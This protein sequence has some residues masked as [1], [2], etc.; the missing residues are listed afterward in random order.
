MQEREKAMCIV[1]KKRLV[2]NYIMKLFNVII[3]NLWS[4]KIV[5][6]LWSNKINLF[7]ILER[8]RSTESVSPSLFLNASLIPYF[9]ARGLANIIAISRPKCDWRRIIS[10][11]NEFV[12]VKN[13]FVYQ[14]SRTCVSNLCI[15]FNDMCIKNILCI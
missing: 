7:F 9:N 14:K 10:F 12:L 4:N 6:N 13:V 2:I 15:K 5:K 3:K 1:Y 8:Q 11:W